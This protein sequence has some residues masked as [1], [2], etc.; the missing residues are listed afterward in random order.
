LDTK[1]DSPY[2]PFSQEAFFSWNWATFDSV[3]LPSFLQR[4]RRTLVANPHMKVFIGSGYYD[5][6]TPFAAVE[7][8]IN[9]LELPDS[10]RKNFQI[11]YYPAGHGFIFHLPSLKKFKQDLLQF[12][13]H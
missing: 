8:S 9:H 10:Y 6:R 1:K 12:Y 3:N 2:I 4:L 5:L 13:E 7:Y 11:E